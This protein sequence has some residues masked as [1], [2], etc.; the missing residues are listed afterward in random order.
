M[1]TMNPL[2]LAVHLPLLALE[3]RPTPSPPSA[4]VDRGRVI[5]ADAAALDAGVSR[6]TGI[7]A[8]RM[9]APSITL[10]ARDSAQEAAALHALACWAGTFT[11][12]ISL[13]G[14]SLLLEVAAS[15]RLFGGLDN[16]A[17]AVAH[18]IGELGFRPMLAAAPTPTAAH[19][20]A[21]CATAARC[22][23]VEAMR[24]QLDALP[25]DVLAAEPCRALR[26]IGMATLGAVR[27]LP[28]APLA[29]RVGAEALAAIARAYGEASDLR[30]DFVFPDRFSLT[31]P[32][33]ATVDS[34][35]ALLFAARR[36]TG[37]LC[38]WLNA[39]QL[40]VRGFSLRLKHRNSESVLPVQFG[41][42][43]ADNQ[44][45]DRV[46]R[47]HLD[48]LLLS[49]P[50]DALQ[51]DA[52]TP[53]AL[54]ARSGTLFGDAGSTQE[55]VDALLER[56]C[57]RLGAGQVYRVGM[58]ADHRP[59]CATRRL[60]AF[61]QAPAPPHPATVMAA[62]ARPL[63]LI[64]PPQPL[65]EV[66]G[67]PYRNGALTLLAGPERIES[68]WWDGGEWRGQSAGEPVGAAAAAVGDV[69]RDYFIALTPGGSWLWIYRDCRADGG[70]YAH[71][72]YA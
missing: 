22:R 42:V 6:G 10:L 52:D 20:L 61:A 27:R 56:L 71:G 11:P 1:K 47:E 15:L 34:A 29:R 33:P 25:V 12:R 44:R 69:R 41:G 66:D 28:R 57:A 8:A 16:I 63:W 62:P 40:G 35:P 58:A 36:L 2:W 60:G 67:R 31:L 4:V 43:S 70:W 72:V 30:A 9:L 17:A 46:L 65:A 7:A 59:E 13:A 32:L 49:A 24:H 53:A 21:R 45:F 39:R 55:G 51:L 14:D 26:R 3:S 48:Q 23:D 50:V 38:G 64:D 68:G 18:G 5:L 19:W 54:A 37:A